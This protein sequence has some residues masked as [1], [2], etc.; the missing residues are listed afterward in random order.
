MALDASQYAA[1]LLQT[2]S[3][4]RRLDRTAPKARTNSR[5]VS[6]SGQVGALRAFVGS[7]MNDRTSARGSCHTT[8]IPSILFCWFPADERWGMASKVTVCGS[9]WPRTKPQ[10]SLATAAPS[11][12]AATKE[13]TPMLIVPSLGWFGQPILLGY[14]TDVGCGAGCRWRRRGRSCRIRGL[15]RWLHVHVAY[16]EDVGLG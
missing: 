1:S 12:S 11:W 10:W 8:S 14:P 3:P 13:S 4:P 6:G 2:S 7:V 5:P 9:I 15:R 16:A